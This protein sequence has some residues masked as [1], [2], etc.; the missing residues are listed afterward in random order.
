MCWGVL[1][2]ALGDTVILSTTGDYQR[3]APH[4]IVT[5]LEA[6]QQNDAADETSAG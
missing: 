5:P 3:A 6:K 4:Q 2:D 1:R